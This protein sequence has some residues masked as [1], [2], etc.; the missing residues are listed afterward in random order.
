MAKRATHGG[1]ARRLWSDASTALMR[2]LFADGEVEVVTIARKFDTD[3]SVVRQM[4]T[5]TTYKG[6][7]GPKADPNDPRLR[8]YRQQPQFSDEDVR[9]AL[10]AYGDED[11]VPESDDE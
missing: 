5:G 2:E 3:P 7:G 9:R 1:A 6:A 11:Y 4:L 8:P 10:L